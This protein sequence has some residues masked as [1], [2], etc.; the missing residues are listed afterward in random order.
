MSSLDI[1]LDPGLDGMGQIGCVSD[2]HYPGAGLHQNPAL[3]S[4]E[5]R[6][7]GISMSY[8][9]WSR[10]IIKD[11]HCA[12]I[13]AWYS[14]G[15][16][17]TLG[18]K[19]QLFDLGEIVY[20]DETGN[21]YRQNPY[22][23]YFQGS[24]AYQ[25]SPHFKTGGSLKYIRSVML[26]D[27]S[28]NLI[29]N[30]KNVDS[31]AIDLGAAYNNKIKFDD[32]IELLWQVGACIRNFGP[33]VKY[34]GGPGIKSDFL[35]TKIQLGI[36][37]SPYFKFNNEVTLNIDFA[38][39][40]EK[41]LVP[42]PPV[43]Y[44]STDSILDGKN[45]D[46]S[47]FRALYQSFYDAPDGLSEEIHEIKHKFGT[48]FRISNNDIFYAA[49]RGGIQTQYILKENEKMTFLGLGCGVYGFS[50]DFSYSHG[51]YN[52]AERNWMIGIGFQAA[53]T[54]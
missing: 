49:L 44:Q 40:A 25:F 29:Q 6:T 52:W 10:P 43:Y 16:K 41:F 34:S 1:N 15:P 9:P 22:D 20:T 5:A 42:S 45:P 46:I 53:W 50:L 35:P 37:G 21:G 11:I 2:N 39:Q 18:I 26:S 24:I 4:G 12:S 13:N 3:L 36:M 17:T 54:S 28:H 19:S 31:Y 33:K 32:E 8:L 7:F 27:P 23:L 30:Y 47:I 51:R 38:Y 48:E 14:V